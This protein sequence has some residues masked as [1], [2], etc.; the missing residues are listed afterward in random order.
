[1]SPAETRA[2]LE[3]MLGVPL[4]RPTPPIVVDRVEERCEDMVVERL[5]LDLG[6]GAA[7]PGLVTRPAWPGPH[8]A[9]LYCHAHGGNYA[10]GANE[11][12]EGRPALHAPYGPALAAAG[13]LA[14]AIDLATFGARAEP[15]EQALSKA[16]LWRGQTLFGHML[17]DLSAALTYLI[18]RTDVRPEHIATLGLSMGAT[19]AFWLA[20]LDG[21]VAAVAHL[22]CF[23]DLRTLVTEGGHERHGI[24]MMVPGLVETVSTGAIAGL[25]A[26]RPQ[27]ICVGLQDPLTPERAIARAHAETARAYAETDAAERLQLLIEPEAGHLETPGM[28]AAVMGFLRRLAPTL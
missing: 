21:R 7:V 18:G 11:L 23:A 6:E 16:L 4:R 12:L 9:V 8:P 26:P 20:G 14:L 10:I 17:A 28:R 27:L 13:F 5:Y 3:A 15:G 25:V 1:M 19:H 22:C 2:R 24:Y